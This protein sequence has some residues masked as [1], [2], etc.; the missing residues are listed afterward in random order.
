[1]EKET[2]RA[3]QNLLEIV[4]EQQN[5]IRILQNNAT[6]SSRKYG[7]DLVERI[8]RIAK[9]VGERDSFEIDWRRLCDRHYAVKS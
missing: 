5:A 3:L 9:E 7:D 2:K 4:R 8:E 1:M 6:Q